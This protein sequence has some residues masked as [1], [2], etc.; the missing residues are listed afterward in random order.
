MYIYISNVRKDSSV[1]HLCV[2]KVKKYL[3]AVGR[4]PFQCIYVTVV[5]S[6]KPGALQDHCSEIHTRP[7]RNMVRLSFQYWTFILRITSA[8][9]QWI[10]AHYVC[11][12]SV[13]VTAKL[14]IP[15]SLRVILHWLFPTT[16]MERKGINNSKW[17][18]FYLGKNWSF[19]EQLLSS[20]FMGNESLIR[21]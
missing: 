15:S 5:K 7:H 4:R 19:Y 9:E 17:V 16:K 14:S 10:W 6:T 21:Y 13:S 20:V 2:F 11:V 8:K 3:L 1:V 18:R 12:F